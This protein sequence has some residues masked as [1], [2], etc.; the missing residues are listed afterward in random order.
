QSIYKSDSQKTREESAQDQLKGA[1][2]LL[3]EDNELN[4]E[5]ALELLAM[6]DVQCI[7]AEH[8]MAALNVLENDSQFDG[9]LMDCQ[10]PVMDGYTATRKIRENPQWTTIPI[11]AMTANTMTGDREKALSAGMNDYIPKPL[12]IREMFQILSKWIKP[13]NP[14]KTSQKATDRKAKRGNVNDLVA[15]ELPGINMQSALRAMEGNM[16]MYQKFLV[17]F[18]KTQRDFG[19]AFLKALQQEDWESATRLA[20]T[21]K[22]LAGTIGAKAL[23][24]S[25]DKLEIASGKQQDT[26]ELQISFQ[27]TQGNLTVVL[28][29]LDDFLHRHEPV[30]ISTTGPQNIIRSDDLEKL[31]SLLEEGDADALEYIDILTERG[32]NEELTQ[33]ASLVHDMDFESAV[34]CAKGLMAKLTST[35]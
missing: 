7:V 4:Q 9:I 28:A 5:L 8:G 30:E 34:T 18:S 29:S 27:D 6:A 22:G 16:K 32:P 35:F 2:L 19:E 1:R 31:I 12:N 3:V 23:Q 25:A 11:I 17:R 10:M 24:E 33:L 14:K 26:S 15:A 20:H 21:M 13:G